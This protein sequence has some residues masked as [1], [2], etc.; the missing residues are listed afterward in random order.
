MSRPVLLSP[1]DKLA[2][3]RAVTDLLKEV[4]IAVD[5]EGV[6]LGKDGPLTL[7]QVGTVDGRVYLFDVML[8]GKQDRR[9]FADVGLD[10][11]LTSK[12]VVKVI[13]SCSGDSAALYHQF[14]IHLENVFDTQVA[15]LVIEEHKGKKL[16]SRKKLQE[17][18]QL[19]SKNAS[20]FEGK[21]DVKLEWSKIEGDFWAKRPMTEDMIAYASGDVTALIPEVYETQKRYIE[22]NK[23]LEKY[24]E[25][26][27][28]EIDLDIDPKWKNIRLDRNRDAQQL[29]I[30]NMQRKYQSAVKFLD[31]QDEDEKKAIEDTN[32]RDLEKCSDVIK[33]LKQ[34]SLI[35][36]LEELEG[37]LAEPGTFCPDR[38]MMFRIGEIIREGDS[39]MKDRAAQAKE[40][41][42]SIVTSD[43]GRK[44]GPGTPIENFS[45]SEIQVIR[46]LRIPSESEKY[47]PKIV[48]IYWTV[49]SYDLDKAIKDFR[50][51]PEEGIH[52][53]MGKVNFLESGSSV[54]TDVK[55]KAREL[56][57]LL[58][59]KI[60]R[61][62]NTNTP[63]NQLS[64]DERVLLGSLRLKNASYP[65]VVEALH[66]KIEYDGLC[67]QMASH[68]IGATADDGLVRKLIF[69]SKNSS[70]P[71]YVKQKADEFLRTL[72]K[73]RGQ[74]R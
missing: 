73:G 28:E 55:R 34:D 7:L 47:S 58:L 26:I 9:F 36:Y 46:A 54:P 18:C 15:H 27:Q 21:E 43:I 37:Q 53:P 51:S 12:A 50:S 35:A 33:K 5:S 6:Q 59:N 64:E 25:R 23:L 31:L 48:D 20:A 44:Y 61:K 17:I 1:K 30:D 32:I 4:L 29:V 3:Q 8:D 65:S 67:S 10:K 68:R 38:S 16:P 19:Y 70:V 66:W 45:S 24:A 41:V 39:L 57:S 56:Q 11:L 2:A 22:D 52:V 69:F 74:R 40:K 13:Q 62:Y 14:G 60:S 42:V 71:R 49:Q 63:V 72:P